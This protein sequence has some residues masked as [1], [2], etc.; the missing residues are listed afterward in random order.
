MTGWLTNGSGSQGSTG[1]I[2]TQYSY[3]LAGNT[4]C[5]WLWLHRVLAIILMAT[6]SVPSAQPN[7]PQWQDTV[8]LATFRYMRLVES[9]QSASG[10]PKSSGKNQ[11]EQT[12]M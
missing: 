12:W 8:I 9:M 2:P 6:T 1:P 4:T 10:H 5:L 7:F 3:M 11:A